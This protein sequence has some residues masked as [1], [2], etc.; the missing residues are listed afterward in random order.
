MGK[1]ANGTGV[2]AYKLQKI[3]NGRV[4]YYTAVES[5]I[6]TGKVVK[7]AQTQEH[8]TMDG[9]P[10]VRETTLR[11]HLHDAA[12]GTGH[13]REFE[14]SYQSLYPEP[15]YDG[16]HWGMSID[17]N[18]CIGC[19]ACII[20]CQSEN[21]IPV[22]GKTQVA[23]RRVMHWI[24][25]DRNYSANPENPRVFFQPMTCQQCDQAP[26]ENVCP[27]SATNHSNEG[28]SQMAYNRCVGTKYCIN[29]CPYK[30]RKF[31]WY[32]FTTNKKFDFNMNEDLGR[33]V[34]NPDVTV[35][36]RGVVEK[37][38]FCVQRIQQ[39]KLEAKLNN[40]PLGDIDLLTA[41]AQAC[42]TRAIR[43][44]NTLDKESVVAR[45]VKDPRNYHVLEEL[46]T[47]PSIGYLTLV[48]NPREGETA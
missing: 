48:R 25:I 26:C 42:P 18:S 29:N 38:T 39:K 40:K 21:N 13:E 23:K 31:N 44:G 20:G 19:N 17:L 8:H 6:D 22:V 16:Y 47:L 45:L 11:E 12:S 43:F 32:R 24:R 4:R 27:V 2:N 15:K 1:V 30:V 14:K 5:Y 35:R 37:C 33:L 28:L 7:L 34:L 9:R 10:I 46:H 36:E 41:C 3:I